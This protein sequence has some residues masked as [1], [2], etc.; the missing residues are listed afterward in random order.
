MDILNVSGQNLKCTKRYSWIWLMNYIAWD[1]PIHVLSSSKNS[2]PSISTHVWQSSQYN[3]LENSFR[4]QMKQFPDTF[5][6]WWSSSRQHTFS[7]NMFLFCQLLNPYSHFLLG[8]QNYIH[9]LNLL[10]GQSIDA[11]SILHHHSVYSLCCNLKGFYLQNCLFG[12]TFNFMFFY[13]LT[14][15][16]GSASDAHIFQDALIKGLSIPEGWYYLADAK[17]PHC[18][19][20]LVFYQ[21][22]CYHLA[23]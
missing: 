14:E 16:E 9:S 13:V 10:W 2:W 11:I 19:Q 7:T 15:W 18:P 12:C 1:T 8:T 5:R 4:E 22:I 17:F 23:E 6:K 21:G 20:L 3:M